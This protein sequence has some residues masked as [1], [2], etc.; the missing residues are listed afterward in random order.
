MGRVIISTST[1][2][3]CVEIGLPCCKLII[4]IGTHLSDGHIKN[5]DIEK[6]AE[7]CEYKMHSRQDEEN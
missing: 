4:I 6:Y 5:T 7:I 2:I 1:E 3:M